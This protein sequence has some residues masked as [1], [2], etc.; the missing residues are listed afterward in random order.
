MAGLGQILFVC[1]GNTC[2][3]PLAEAVARQ[4]IRSSGL[5]ATVAS[6]GIGAMDDEPASAMARAVARESGLDLESHRARLLTRGDV[7]AARLVLT[8]GPRQLE[9]I[10]VLAPEASDRVFLVSDYASTGESRQE[11]RDPF[12]GDREAYR[13][14]LA[15]LRPVVEQAL[16]RFEAEAGKRGSHGRHA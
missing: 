6:A 14:T 5:D 12:G 1:T 13:R 10:R 16:Q 8:M 15:E 11:I 7:L 9:F 4:V 3:S 2:R